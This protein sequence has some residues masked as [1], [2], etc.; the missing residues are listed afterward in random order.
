[1]AR[2]PDGRPLAD[3]LVLAAR[4][5]DSVRGTWGEV[6]TLRSDATGTVILPNDR[7]AF[8]EIRDRTNLLGAWIKR[9]EVPEGSFRTWT[10]DTLRSLRGT[11]PDRATTGAGRFYL[12]SSFHSTDLGVVET[13]FDFGRISPGVYDL[14]LDAAGNDPRPMGTILMGST[15]VRY[16]GSGNILLDGDTT[17]SPFW[18][19]DFEA[20]P[21]APLLRKSVPQVAGWYVWSTLMEVAQPTSSSDS[22]MR[23]AIGP[24]SLRPSRAF[25]ARFLATSPDARIGLGLTRLHLDLSRR[26]GFCFRYRCDS[27]VAV[28]FQRDSVG[29][30]RPAMMGD[31]PSSTGWVDACLATSDLVPNAQTPDS[32]KSWDAFGKSVLTIEFHVLAGGTYLDLDD[33]RM[34]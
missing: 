34:R 26:G 11:W 23:L 15:G 28:Q 12:D 24:D 4:T 16:T 2:A 31:L 30:G 32:L 10:L 17:G 20:D 5:W 19:E 6:D 14:R 27:S 29:G 25:H 9:V 1:M 13:S 21:P 3:A 18:I 22:A 7:Y 33:I 8:L